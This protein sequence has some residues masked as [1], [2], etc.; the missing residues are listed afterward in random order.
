MARKKQTRT[1]KKTKA[2]ADQ[3]VALAEYAATALV[4]AE[5][6]GIKAKAVEEFPLSEEERTTVAHLPALAAK[7]KKKLAKTDGPYTVA[8]VAGMVMAIAESLVDAEPKQQVT[9]LIVAKKL[10][11]CLQANITTSNL[12][13]AKRTRATPADTVY[14]F[15]ITLLESRPRSG[16]ES[17]CRTARSTSCTNTSR[18]RWAGRTRTCT[19]SGSRTSFTATPN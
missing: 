12:R 1:T 2:I 8:E 5:Q 17:R 6:L 9:L 11:D 19:T 10:M 15:K 4:A 18:R 7:L 13:P 14:Q 3:G 16:G